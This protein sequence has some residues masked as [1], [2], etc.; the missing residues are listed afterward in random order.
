MTLTLC[1]TIELIK[2]SVAL[3]GR[4]GV[5]YYTLLDKIHI[6]QNLGWF[7]AERYLLK[8]DYEFNTNDGQ[9]LKSFKLPI[10][11]LSKV[12]CTGPSTES[13]KAFGIN[14]NGEVPPPNSPILEVLDLVGNAKQNGCVLSE[15]VKALSVTKI[16]FFVDKICGMGILEKRFIIPNKGKSSKRVTIKSGI[17]HLKRFSSSYNPD[18]DNVQ[19][20]S[21][22]TVKDQIY[23]YI[24]SILENCNIE[25]MPATDLAK[26]IGLSYRKMQ[27]LRN[28]VIS[29]SK[30]SNCKIHCFVDYCNPVT[31]SGILSKC[32]LAW[33]FGK[34]LDH[35]INDEDSTCDENV[36]TSAIV[37]SSSM[38]HIINVPIY[39]QI[40]LLIRSNEQGVTSNDIKTHL[41]ITT[42]RAY[43]VYT[44]F[45]GLLNYS[46]LKFQIGKSVIL[47][48]FENKID[49]LSVVEVSSQVLGKQKLN[50][51]TMLVNDCDDSEVESTNKELIEKQLLSRKKVSKSSSL[52]LNKNQNGQQLSD[53]QK[54]RTSIVIDYLMKVFFHPIFMSFMENIYC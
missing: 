42:K 46:T 40:A 21:D 50:K 43:K 36:N 35:D 45:V 24:Y 4:N 30:K 7:I 18:F 52:E 53:M 20:S 32:K 22:G 47:K 37:K 51:K 5:M 13:W 11:I 31:T 34:K 10:I 2:D 19:I 16:H 6:S 3:C 33:C 8:D 29:Q 9:L 15:V 17:L 27:Y 26:H 39:E 25:S 38:L 12:I 54:V 1:E 44:D 41:G 48:L 28:H 14:S 49:K 23:D